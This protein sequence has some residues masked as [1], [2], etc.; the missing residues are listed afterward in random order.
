MQKDPVTVIGVGDM[1]GD[2]FGNGLLLSEELAAGRGLQPHAYLYRSEPGRGASFV[3][4]QRLF[5]LPRSSWADYDTKLIFGRRR[6]LPAQRQEH[7][8]SPQM[9]ERFDIKCRQAGP[10]ELLNA[11]LKAPVDSAV[12]RRYWYLRQIQQG[13]PSP[14]RRQG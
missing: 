1:A 13:K 3:E 6:N 10:D 14:T 7:R 5:D 8:I 11:L 9:K 2:V 4:R 12:E